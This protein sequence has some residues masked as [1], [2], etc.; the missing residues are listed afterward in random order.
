[1]RIGFYLRGNGKVWADKFS[2]EE[3]GPEVPETHPPIPNMDRGSDDGRS[4][5]AVGLLSG[6]GN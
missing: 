5:R 1:M 4:N 6:F 2:V 3:V